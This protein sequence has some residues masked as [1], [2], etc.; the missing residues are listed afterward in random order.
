MNI[1][2]ACGVCKKIH[3]LIEAAGS[4]TQAQLTLVV[5]CPTARTALCTAAL[6]ALQGLRHYQV[7]NLAGSRQAHWLHNALL[8]CDV[9]TAKPPAHRLEPD[10][11]RN[12]SLLYDK[13]QQ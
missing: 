13:G 1:H 12:Q 7:C 9:W 11:Q 10:T 2:R 6:H 8:T 3:R 5:I 4:R